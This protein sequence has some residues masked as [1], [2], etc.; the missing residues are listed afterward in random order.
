MR[1]RALIILASLYAA[2][3]VGQAPTVQLITS[4]EARLPSATGQIS[5]RGIT[6]GPGIKVLSPDPAS[7]TVKGPFDLKIAFEPRGGST[8]DASSAKLIYLK[9]PAVDLTPR[10]KS[11]IKPSGIEILSAAAP[12]GEHPIRVTVRDSEGRQG[13]VEFK[14]TVK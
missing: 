7:Q 1:I 8:I 2:A 10:V 6:R 14:L 3:A 12:A 13:S 5:S 9:N 11:G 4:E